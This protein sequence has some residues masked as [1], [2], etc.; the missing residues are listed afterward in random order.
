MGCMHADGRRQDSKSRPRGRG[1]REHWKAHEARKRVVYE[2]RAL[3][4]EGL[5]R[6][7]GN[8]VRDRFML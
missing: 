8:T 3:S 6:S 2:P 7:S 4:S 1:E 5:V